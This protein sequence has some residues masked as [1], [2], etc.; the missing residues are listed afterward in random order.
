MAAVRVREVPG[1]RGGPD[2]A[3]EVGRRGDGD[4]ADV[5]AGVR[6]R[7]CA[8]ASSTRG[9][10]RR[11][12]TRRCSSSSRKPGAERFDHVLEAL[13]RGIDRDELQRRTDIDPW[14]LHRAR[15]SWR[16][17]RRGAAFA[18][19]RTF[20]SV[21]TCA[22][23]F[24]ARTPYYY[25]GWERPGPNGVAGR[26]RARVA[27]ERRDPRLGP[28]PDRPG[29]RVRLL[30]RA[31][32]PDRPRARAR[33]GDDQLQPGDGLDRL[34]H[35]GP[36]VLRAAHARGRARRVRG[37]EAGGRDRS[38]RRPDAA[39]ARGGT[40]RGGGHDPRHEHRR[41][42]PRRGPLPLRAAAR[43]ARLQ[44]AA[45][46]DRHLGGRGARDRPDG[47]LPAARA[48][49]LRARRTRHGD[50]LQRRRAQ[51]L[52]GP[53]RRR[54]RSRPPHDLPRPLPGGLDR[55]RR[56]RA[57]RRD[58]CLDRGDHAARRG[59]GHPLRRLR[60]RAAAAR[61]RR[62]DAR[63]DLRAD[64]RD[65]QGARRRRADQRPVRGRTTRACT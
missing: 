65:R 32:R 60:L 41:H 37:R 20:K 11:T 45:V 23:E 55:G 63:D 62:R 2:D 47:R 61:A 54:R 36:A 25:S 27:P 46:R 17:G 52:P 8:R 49:E 51:G 44:G 18:G 58:R 19:E 34:R 5:P 33:R 16:A 64:N 57:L 50:R 40:A 42:R 4:R 29:N 12:T 10:R 13:R 30:L 31:R 9:R 38:V 7:R 24:A 26:G 14:F 43:P 59:G 3:H 15:P 56:R 53:R 21:D 48:A 1:R 22:A 28:E 35:L 39:E 6:A